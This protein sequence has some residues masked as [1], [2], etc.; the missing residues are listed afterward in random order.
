MQKV[1]G[2][3]EALILFAR[4]IMCVL[5]VCCNP[6][7]TISAHN[8][9]GHHSRYARPR[10]VRFKTWLY[11]QCAHNMHG[12]HVRIYSVATHGRLFGWFFRPFSDQQRRLHNLEFSCQRFRQFSATLRPYSAGIFLENY[13]LTSF[14]SKKRRRTE[15]IHNSDDFHV[16]VDE[17]LVPKVNVPNVIFNFD[18]LFR[19]NQPHTFPSASFVFFGILEQGF[20]CILAFQPVQ[21]VNIFVQRMIPR[22]TINQSSGKQ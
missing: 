15:V 18:T 22:P 17:F 9:R 5:T 10:R 6:P 13:I 2:V 7:F 11:E 21:G 8:F 4:N 20:L 12:T 16:D 1:R 14:E 3:T 19:R